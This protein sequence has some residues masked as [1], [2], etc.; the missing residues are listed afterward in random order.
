MHAAARFNK[1]RRAVWSPA[2]TAL[3]VMVHYGSILHQKR[4]DWPRKSAKCALI[5][6]LETRGG[7]LRGSNTRNQSGEKRS[8]YA[9]PPFLSFPFPFG[10]RRRDKSE[11]TRR[12]VQGARSRRIPLFVFPPA[13]TPIVRPRNKLA[14]TIEYISH[15]DSERGVPRAETF[16][17]VGARVPIERLLG[18]DEPKEWILRL[19]LRRK[20]SSR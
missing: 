10:L 12:A 2:H 19:W 7:I 20:R 16:F 17:G 15:F 14:S 11:D 5:A 9:R 6:A 3:G 13:T 1:S 8:T 18:D 4:E